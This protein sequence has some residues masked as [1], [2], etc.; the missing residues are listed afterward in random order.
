MIL[1]LTWPGVAA[2]ITLVFVPSVAMFAVTSIM[3]GGHILLIGDVIQGQ[4]SAQA[5]SPSEPPWEFCC[6]SCSCSALCW[7]NENS[8]EM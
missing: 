1:P 4:F 2:G 5:T 3:S 7:F 6:C 8:R